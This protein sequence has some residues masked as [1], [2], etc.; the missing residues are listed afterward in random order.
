MPRAIHALAALFALTAAPVL[1]QDAAGNAE[2]GQKVFDFG[3]GYELYKE[4][5][6]DTVHQLVDGYVAFTPKGALGL[7]AL[8]LGERAKALLRRNEKL[9]KALKSLRPG[10]RAAAQEKDNDVD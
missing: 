3:V 6:A 8:R 9:W 1:A 7:G 2:A 10:G 4:S 5:W